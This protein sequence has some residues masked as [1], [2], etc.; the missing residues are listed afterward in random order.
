MANSVTEIL[1][2][3]REDICTNYCKYPAV[4]GEGDSE[5]DRLMHERCESCPLNRL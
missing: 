4:Y 5:F 2:E 1:E 3:V